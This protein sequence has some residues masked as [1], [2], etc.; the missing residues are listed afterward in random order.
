MKSKFE[1][2]YW[3]YKTSKTKD[4]WKYTTKENTFKVDS[5]GNY[6]LLETKFAYEMYK[7]GSK[8]FDKDKELDE[9]F[10]KVNDWEYLVWY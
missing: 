6:T 3:Q 8:A 4:P 9:L 7:A 10:N 1:Q 2:D 5:K